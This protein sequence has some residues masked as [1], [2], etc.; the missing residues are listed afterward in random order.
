MNELD[1]LALD[2][3]LLTMLVKVH[4]TG[5]V[6]AAAHDLNVT[7]STVSHGL[8]RLRSITGDD[9]FV[10]MGR[11]ITPTE[12]ADTLVAEAKEILHRMQCFSRA[13]TYDPAQDTRP[14]SIAATDYEIELIIRPFIHRLRR[15]APQVQIRVRRALPDREW[16]QLLR[17]GEV[18]LVLAPELK[19]LE[20]DIKQRRVLEDD[21]DVVY[22]D[23]SQRTAPDSLDSYCTADH[24]IMALSASG[25]TSVDQ[26]LATMGRSRRI[27]VSLPGFSS[28]AAVLAGSDMVALMP[29][30]LRDSTFLGLA[31][32]PPPFAMPTETISCIW[33]VR[34]DASERH[35]WMR[36][37]IQLGSEPR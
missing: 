12:K 21:R 28:I 11:T 32:C 4:E 24:V 16:V 36:K 34:S 35:I 8:N 31:F 1:E 15:L 2:G 10:P 25:K 27:A 22:F 29:V 26:I 13:D 5:S 14:F 17:S 19:T 20:T 6:T 9:L 30:R 3:R 33:H 37:Q 7:Q 23:A 18:D